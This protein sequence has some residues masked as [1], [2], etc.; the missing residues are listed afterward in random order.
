MA[1]TALHAQRDGTTPDSRRLTPAPLRRAAV[2]LVAVLVGALALVNVP[3]MA[4]AVP[5]TGA[6]T[7]VTIVRDGDGPVHLEDQVQINATW[8]APAGAVAGD[9]FSLDFPTDPTLVAAPIEL[10]LMSPDNLPVATCSVTAAG[11]LC[12]LTSYI[13]THTDVRGTLS[14]TAM[15]TSTTT[16]SSVEFVAG[17]TSILVPLPGGV[18]GLGTLPYFPTP[19]KYGWVVQDGTNRAVWHIFVPSADMVDAAGNTLLLTDTI[20]SRLTVDPDTIWVDFI[21]K[22]DWNDG[23]YGTSGIII[24][25]DEDGSSGGTGYTFTSGPTADQFQIKILTPQADEGLYHI[26]YY[27]ALP[28]DA[29]PGSIYTNDIAGASQWTVPAGIKYQGAGGDGGGINP[30]SISLTKRVDGAAPAGDFTFSIACTSSKGI[31]VT[32]FPRTVDLAAD[33]TITLD[34]IP[35][36]SVCDIT[37]TNSLGADSVTYADS[38]TVTVTEDSPA[39]IDVVATNHFAVPMSIVGGLAVTKT[40][41][42]DVPAGTEY[43]V[44]YSYAVDGETVTGTLPVLAGGT[45]TLADLPVGTVVTLTEPVIPAITGS[46]WGAPAFTIVGGS[47]TPTTTIDVTIAADTTVAVNLTN[48]ATVTTPPVVVPPV[49]TPPVTTPPAV[50]TPPVPPVAPMPITGVLGTYGTHQPAALTAVAKHQT[51]AMTGASTLTALLAAAGLTAVG[52]VL[53]AS[54]RRHAHQG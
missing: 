35:V 44:D 51:L 32:G 49:V 18:I 45:A 17:N 27:A 16:K 12:T 53:V 54:R 15:F 38:S 20:D 13:T 40:V 30:R 39:V 4:Q 37:E 5:L 7:S 23:N 11:F 28:A 52:I 21:K 34:S 3:T 48:T 25:R 19:T 26:A 31:Y 43:T 46:T 41:S 2:A 50:V 29:V 6:I 10:T 22:T 36:G 24:P 47:A 8:A 42:G 9:T 33:E 14:F 1:H